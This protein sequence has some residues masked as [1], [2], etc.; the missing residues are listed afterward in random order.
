MSQG[1]S[2]LDGK[3]EAASARHSGGTATLAVSGLLREPGQAV[4]AFS[5]YQE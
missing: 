5:M 4:L 1:G 2:E 3:Q